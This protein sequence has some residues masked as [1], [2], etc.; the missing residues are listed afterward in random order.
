[1]VVL[2]VMVD[3][4]LLGSNSLAWYSRIW[5]PPVQLIDSDALFS[6]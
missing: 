4:A 6:L 5:N 2:H 1:M 3:T